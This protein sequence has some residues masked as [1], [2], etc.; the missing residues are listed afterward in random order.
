MRDK[1][2]WL[3]WCWIT[4]KSMSLTVLVLDISEQ[5]EYQRSFYST[6]SE[7]SHLT[8]DQIHQQDFKNGFLNW[9]V[10]I[11]F[12]KKTIDDQMP[13][14][15]LVFLIIGKEKNVTFWNPFYT[16][17]R[18]HLPQQCRLTSI[19]LQINCRQIPKRPRRNS[20]HFAPRRTN[21]QEQGG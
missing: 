20:T 4:G 11:S 5:S 10:K 7:N 2:R 19:Y 14:Y 6:A 21:G 12:K 18:P 15:K 9:L 13:G 1:S 8:P 16:K 3:R 17:D